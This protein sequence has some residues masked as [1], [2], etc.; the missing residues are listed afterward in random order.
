MGL[1]A[2]T[3]CR[4]PIEPELKR[5]F[6]DQRCLNFLSI[7]FPP[8]LSLKF[9]QGPVSLWAFLTWLFHVGVYQKSFYDCIN[10]GFQ[11][12]HFLSLSFLLKKDKKASPAYRLIISSS[13]LCQWKCTCKWDLAQCNGKPPTAAASLFGFQFNLSFCHFNRKPN[14]AGKWV[15]ALEFADP[16]C[17]PQRQTDCLA[18]QALLQNTPLLIC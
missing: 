14:V 10:S 16:T 1:L 9:I 5:I 12:E 6:E 3:H 18:E 17:E 13:P 4:I 2:D 11:R 7:C 15:N 8:T